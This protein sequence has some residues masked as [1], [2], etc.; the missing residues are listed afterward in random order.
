MANNR[1]CRQVR[2]L[3]R[4]SRCFGQAFSLPAPGSFLREIEGLILIGLAGLLSFPLAL[5]SHR[6][7]PA[8]LMDNPGMWIV[9]FFGLDCA[10]CLYQKT[11]IGVN[12][13]KHRWDWI[14]KPA[15]E[16]E[17]ELLRA[18]SPPTRFNCSA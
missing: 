14:I 13:V 6:W 5:C 10:V 9:A 2:L 3:C 4:L 7:F 8:R 1:P 15:V 18:S 11:R 12:T 17:K 16:P